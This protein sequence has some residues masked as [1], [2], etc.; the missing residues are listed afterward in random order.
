MVRLQENL[1]HVHC[2]RQSPILWSDSRTGQLWPPSCK[3]PLRLAVDGEGER[4]V[5][6]LQRHQIAHWTCR[7]WAG[8][9]SLKQHP[10]CLSATANRPDGPTSS[11]HLG[12]KRAG[13]SGLEFLGLLVAVIRAEQQQPTS[14]R[15]TDQG[16][17]SSGSGVNVWGW[18][19]GFLT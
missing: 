14:L 2:R 19:V 8:C 18:G 4:C 15:I 17:L 1:L 9:Y 10:R 3:P 5:T 12:E 16:S 7:Y 11:D 13:T 6:I